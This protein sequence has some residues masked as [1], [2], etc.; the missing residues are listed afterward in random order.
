MLSEYETYAVNWSY[1]LIMVG[2][3]I[4]VCILLYVLKYRKYTAVSN[5]KLYTL[6]EFRG[7]LKYLILVL[8]ISVL[9]LFTIWV[10]PSYFSTIAIILAPVII[11]I[12]V[13]FV[14]LFN[15]YFFKSKLYIYIIAFK[16]ATI[17]V[18]IIPYW[19]NFKKTK[20]YFFL[21]YTFE[22]VFVSVV[23]LFL[24]WSLKEIIIYEIIRGDYTLIVCILG[25]FLHTLCLKQI[26]SL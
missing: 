2:V 18:I 14:Y 19:E 24:F 10:I 20:I 16:R 1:S 21:L 23:I 15:F 6:S 7:L 5:K 3:L 22:T 13:S 9:I 25:K 12:T 17:I 8:V 11:S 26:R 4:S